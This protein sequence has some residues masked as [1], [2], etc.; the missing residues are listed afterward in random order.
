MLCFLA[1]NFGGCDFTLAVT[2]RNLLSAMN[3]FRVSFWRELPAEGTGQ[4]RCQIK[5][6]RQVHSG[7]SL[8]FGPVFVCVADAD[9]QNL[10]IIFQLVDDKVRLHRMNANGRR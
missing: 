2:F 7:S 5:G 4:A 3:A 6:W 10:T 8:A 9:D 1:T